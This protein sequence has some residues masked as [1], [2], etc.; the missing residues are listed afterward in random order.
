MSRAINLLLAGSLL[1]ALLAAQPA[2]AGS[3]AAPEVTDAPGDQVLVTS[4]GATPIPADTLGIGKAADIVAAWVDNETA[5]AIT[6]H[7]RVNSDIENALLQDLGGQVST[8][9][10]AGYTYNF[11]ANAGLRTVRA[12]A[13]VT[14]SGPTDPT[15]P[16]NQA[17]G[18]AQNLTIAGS[19]LSFQ[20]PRS[21][22]DNA[23][24]GSHLTNLSV[25]VEGRIFDANQVPLTLLDLAPNTGFGGNYTFQ[26][27][28]AGEETT[29]GTGGG[30]GNPN[31]APGCTYRATETNRSDADADC[32]PDRWERQY[33]PTLSQDGNGD[34]DGDGCNNRCE[35]LHGTDPTKK[36]SDGDGASD[37]DEIREGTSPTDAGSH[38]A[39]VTT[40]TG[41]NTQTGT[42]T[43]TQ[44]GTG[45][46]TSTSTSAP[47][48]STDEDQSALGKIEADAGYAVASGA[49]M[50]AVVL[51]SLIGL[52]GRWSA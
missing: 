27:D 2:T 8:V 36:D 35:Y 13:L 9:G 17:T 49:A 14:G 37:G 11:T 47:A 4:Q 7:I 22:L 15:S 26:M 25:R 51:I 34:P 32:L 3:A 21:A 10:T 31:G 44:T 42:N 12:G 46:S 20:I 16:H 39:A 5:T 33:F 18:S 23:T 50:G 29:P 48:P 19:M 45:T 30:S 24:E 38:P 52:F 28:T 1:L 40:P 6:V 41:T 43:N